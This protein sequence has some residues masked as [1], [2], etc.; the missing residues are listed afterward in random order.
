MQCTQQV[1]FIS[2]LMMI[3]WYV[4]EWV[5]PW[6]I[7]EE[8]APFAPSPVPSA[9]GRRIPC[10]PQP[11]RHIWLERQTRDLE[12]GQALQSV[13]NANSGLRLTG[14]CSSQTPPRSLGPASS[15]SCADSG[16]A[17][18]PALKVPLGGG[19]GSGASPTGWWTFGWA[20]RFGMW[21]LYL[22]APPQPPPPPPPR[23]LCDAHN[24]LNSS[25]CDVHPPGPTGPRLPRRPSHGRIPL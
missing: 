20:S 2:C 23:S 10:D 14:T 4:A 15:R 21:V 22:R 17:P 24:T 13:P 12:C 5:P 18:V 25:A 19:G 8:A 16:A 1:A 6:M 9:T 7:P 11:N 3:V